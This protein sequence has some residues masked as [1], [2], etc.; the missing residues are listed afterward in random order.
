MLRTAVGRF[1]FIAL[2]E[3]ISFLV[4]LAIAM[5]LKYVWDMPIYV[6]VVG[7]LHG[8]LFVLY[9][10][11]LMLAALEKKWSLGL[12]CYAALASFIPFATFVLDV[13]LKRQYS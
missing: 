6:T 11:G 1:R 2:L 9:M 10:L 4:L 8:L 5:P 12:I 13:R 3:G 7:A